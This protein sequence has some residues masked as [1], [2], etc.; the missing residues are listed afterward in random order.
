MRDERAD[1]QRRLA[2]VFG[3]VLPATTADERAQSG[4]GSGDGEP[5]DGEPAERWL[6]ENRPPHHDP[7]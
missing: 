1:E 2:E 4:D 3:D 7:T 5:S 6:R